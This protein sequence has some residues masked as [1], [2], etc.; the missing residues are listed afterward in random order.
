MISAWAELTLRVLT[1]IA[2]SAVW[3]FLI[4]LALYVAG[5]FAWTAYELIASI[6]KE[7]KK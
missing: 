2:L 7:V 5:K 6:V 1:F 4:G 3:L